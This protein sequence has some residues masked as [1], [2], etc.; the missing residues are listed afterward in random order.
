MEGGVEPGG[1]IPEP[2][3]CP[4]MKAGSREGGEGA[5]ELHGIEEG[6]GGGGGLLVR[7]LGLSDDHHH[8]VLGPESLVFTAGDCLPGSLVSPPVPVLSTNTKYQ[9]Q[10]SLT[11]CF[12]Q[13]SLDNLEQYSPELYLYTVGHCVVS[14]HAMVGGQVSLG[15]MTRSAQIVTSLNVSIQHSTEHWAPR[16]GH[17]GRATRRS[18]PDAPRPEP[19]RDSELET[20]AGLN[21][22]SLGSAYGHRAGLTSMVSPS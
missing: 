11:R 9:H 5:G 12:V 18:P 2:R 17:P 20:R 16:A 13:N 10:D 22:H 8:N 15:V 1:G 3:I 21:Y 4:W 7:H 6:V 19:R 14:S